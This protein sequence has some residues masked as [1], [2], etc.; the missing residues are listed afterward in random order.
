MQETTRHLLS[1]ADLSGAEMA[2]LLKAA[3]SL[4]KKPQRL[5]E[6]PQL[7]LL[8]EKPSLR[9]RVSFQVAM[10]LGKSVNVQSGNVS[11]LVKVT[12]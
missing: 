12:R 11:Q 5:L 10:P 2:F 8:F 6:G 1:S 4:K 9:T 3:A 7:A